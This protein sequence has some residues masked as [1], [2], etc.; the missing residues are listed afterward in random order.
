MSLL[1]ISKIHHTMPMAYSY[2]FTKAALVSKT[3]SM[4]DDKMNIVNSKIKK[5]IMK[6]S[7]HLAFYAKQRNYNYGGTR[8]RSNCRIKTFR[9]AV[10]LLPSTP[11]GSNY[12]RRG[13]T[14][15]P[16]HSN[17][18]QVFYLCSGGGSNSH[19]LSDIRS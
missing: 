15:S 11:R 13:F 6:N 7:T 19:A 18:F 10:L 16:S 4:Q 3:L 9:S 17:T 12:F 2:T 5:I 8:T 1:L 14:N